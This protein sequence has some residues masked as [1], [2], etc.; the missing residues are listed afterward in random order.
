MSSPT[1]LILAASISAGVLVACADLA[2]SGPGTP[3]L[4]IVSGDGQTGTAGRPLGAPLVVRVRDASGR[5][6]A[7]APVSWTVITGYGSVPFASE[8]NANGRSSVNWILGVEGVHQ[9][10]RA[11]ITFG[12]DSSPSPFAPVT[13]GATANGAA[14]NLTSV[15]GDAQ[16]AIVGDTLPVPLRVR[17]VT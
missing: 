10:V 15:A 6:V 16:V 3:G 8:T 5:V 9:T 12:P 4:S 11:S 14:T 1:P 17:A 13:F 7:A 2:G